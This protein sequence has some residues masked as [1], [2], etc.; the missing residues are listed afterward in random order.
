MS[1]HGEGGW[2]EL[3]R[4]QHVAPLVGAVIQPEDIPVPDVGERDAG[5]GEWIRK[6]VDLKGVA[7][8]PEF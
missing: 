4:E 8:P 6:L 3:L 2:L 5:D 1:D 7:R